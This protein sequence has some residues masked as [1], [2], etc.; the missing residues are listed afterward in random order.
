MYA[1]LH[2]YAFPTHP[3]SN[4]EYREYRKYMEYREYREHSRGRQR[5]Y[6]V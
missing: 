2:R 5:R 1:L 3:Y 4:R 6:S